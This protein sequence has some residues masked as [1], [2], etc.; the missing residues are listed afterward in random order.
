MKI[1]IFSISKFFIFLSTET[2]EQVKVP[3]CAVNNKF[4]YAK[5]VYDELYKSSLSSVPVYI[6]CLNK[7]CIDGKT[8]IFVAQYPQSYREEER[9]ESGEKTKFFHILFS[10][11]FSLV[12]E[13]K[14]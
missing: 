4:D 1:L 5:G 12:Y 2:D 3:L 11:A 13:T 7:H 14:G 10:V 6:L 8:I 9:T